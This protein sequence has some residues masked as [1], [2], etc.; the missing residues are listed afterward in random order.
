[1]MEQMTALPEL[2]DESKSFP[3]AEVDISGVNEEPGTLS[4]VTMVPHSPCSILTMDSLTTMVSSRV[5]SGNLVFQVPKSSHRPWDA[6]KGFLCLY[7]SYFTYSGLWFPLPKV[8]V[9]YCFQC[10]MAISQLT[11]AAVR[12][13]V[14]ILTLAAELGVEVDT[15]S[16]EEMAT[17]KRVPNNS[18]RFYVGMKTQIVSMSA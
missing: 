16:F 1:M 10:K 6:P 2:N 5:L 7:E 17:F 3:L 11:R 4:R 12:N 13:I 9:N 14:G 18:D 15:Q 8:L